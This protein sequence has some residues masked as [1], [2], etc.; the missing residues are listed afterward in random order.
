MVRGPRIAAYSVA[1]ALLL[2]ALLAGRVAAACDDASADCQPGELAAQAQRKT[3]LPPTLPPLPIIAADTP[4]ELLPYTYARVLTPDLPVY[5]SPQDGLSGAEPKRILGIGL[6][7]GFLY[8]SVDDVTTVEGVAWARINPNEYVQA[9]HL[10][11]VAGSAF[12]GYHIAGELERPMA[13]MVR[14]FRPHR[15]PGG[16]VNGDAAVLMRYTVVQV[17]ATT[18]VDGWDWYLV[19]PDQWVEQRNVGLVSPKT[20]PDAV[21]ASRWIEID[22]YEQTLTVYE[23]ERPIYATLTSTGLP[24]WYTRPGVFKIYARRWSAP[25]SG[26]Y[27]DDRLDYYALQQ[28]P[29][30]MYF[31]QSIALHGAYW[32]D[33]FGFRK[34]HGCVNLSPTDARWLFDWASEGDYVWVHDPSG[35]T[36]IEDDAHAAISGP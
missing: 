29:W 11:S 18:T 1:L 19:G 2:A 10:S 30:T 33:G 26:S 24:E 9:E 15:T 13:F 23:D 25:M 27:D 32:H 8:V 12:A 16:E 36:P 21:A 22:L 6:G 28:V 7:V 31:D 34:S 20:P 5:A 4:D 17:F 35:E 3:D 14:N